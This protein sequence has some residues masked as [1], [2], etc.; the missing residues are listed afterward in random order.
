VA[1][2]SPPCAHVDRA[3]V[4]EAVDRALRLG[5]RQTASLAKL[6]GRDASVRLRHRLGDRVDLLLA[7]PARAGEESAQPEVLGAEEERRLGVLAVAVR[8]PDLL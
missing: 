3:R 6:L 2:T 4:L 8:P 1:T 7:D 5:L